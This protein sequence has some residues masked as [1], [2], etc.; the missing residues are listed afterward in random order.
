M[1]FKDKLREKAENNSTIINITLTGQ[2]NF[3]KEIMEADGIDEETARALCHGLTDPIDYHYTFGYKMADPVW[4]LAMFTQPGKK[5]RLRARENFR[6]KLCP[7]EQIL[8]D[9]SLKEMEEKWT[10]AKKK[11]KESN[12]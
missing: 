4:Q 2:N 11:K 9:E 5:A 12:G 3:I 1:K 8:F 7:E 10:V 6:E